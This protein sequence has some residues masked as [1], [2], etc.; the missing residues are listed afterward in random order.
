MGSNIELTLRSEFKLTGSPIRPDLIPIPPPPPEAKPPAEKLKPEFG[1]YNRRVIAGR[2][3][4]VINANARTVHGPFHQPYIIRRFWLKYYN[5]LAVW[6]ETD[7]FHVCYALDRG[8][9]NPILTTGF[10]IF[11]A[12]KGSDQTPAYDWQ[13]NDFVVYP[14]LAVYLTPSYLKVEF[15]QAQADVFNFMTQYVFELDFWGRKKDALR[16][17]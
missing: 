13:G 14:N 5:L 2:I 6:V 1:F 15:A 11:D 3:Q 7:V 8:L 10:S 4:H 9:S 17:I 16:R 12:A